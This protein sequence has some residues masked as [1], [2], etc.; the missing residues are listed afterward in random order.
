M[1]TWSSLEPTATTKCEPTTIAWAFE[2][3]FGDQGIAADQLQIDPRSENVVGETQLHERRLE[4]DAPFT[5]H[6]QELGCV[7]AAY[8]DRRVTRIATL[9]ASKNPERVAIR[10][11]T[12]RLPTEGNAR[13]QGHTCI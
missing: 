3:H 2:A 13:Q 1:P 8:I 6:G 9:E 4:Q 5:K 11:W 7:L 10:C 12:E